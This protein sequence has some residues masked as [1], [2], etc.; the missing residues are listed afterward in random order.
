MSRSLLFHHFPS[1]REYYLAVVSA[2][3]DHL[4]DAAEVPA[5]TPVA[6]RLAEIVDA[7]VAFVAVHRAE[8]RALVRHAG[9][10]DPG[11]LDVFDATRVELARRFLTAAGLRHT[12][13]REVAAR[14]WL[15]MAEELVLGGGGGPLPDG[16]ISGSAELV[17][18]FRWIVGRF[19]Q[20]SAARIAANRSS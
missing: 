13:A 17:E 2:A 4:L 12:L 6:E 5:G 20:P 1:K 9:G 10:G 19:G 11:V 18:A 14:S 15:A 8:Y 16:R 7:Y 3:A